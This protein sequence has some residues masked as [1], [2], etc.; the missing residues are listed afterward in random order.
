M[1]RALAD[2]GSPHIAA[3]SAGT[4][5]RST[6]ETT[7]LGLLQA[8]PQGRQRRL[9]D[10][11]RQR[12]RPVRR[13]RP[14]RRRG[15]RRLRRRGRAAGR[16]HRRG[17]RADLAASLPPAG[18]S[19]GVPRHRPRSWRSGWRRRWPSSPSSR[20]YADGAARG[21][22]TRWRPGPHRSR[23]SGCTAT[24]TWARCCARSDGW[25]VLDFEGE[26]ARPLAER[27][28]L[29]SPLRDVAGMLRSLR[30]RRP[31]PARRAP[32][33]P[34]LA[35]R[36]PEWAERNRQAFCDGYARAA[37]ADPRDESALLRAFELD[38]AVYEVRLR[39]AQPPVLA[40]DPARLHRPARRRCRV[41]GSDKRTP[42]RKPT[43]R[44]TPKAAPQPVSPKAAA[45]ATAPV[46]AP[47]EPATEAPADEAPA[48]R[49]SGRRG[50]R[51]GCRCSGRAGR[52]GERPGRTRGHRAGRRGRPV[53]PV[54]RG[55]GA[56]G[57]RRAPRPARRA[58]AHP[59]A[60]GVVLRT[61]R[62]EAERVVAHLAGNDVELAH[63]HAGVWEATVPGGSPDDYRLDGDLPR[64]ELPGGRP[65]PVPA[66]PRRG[67]PAPDRRGPARAALGRCSARTSAAT[68][69]R[70]GRSPAPRSPCGRPTPAACGSSATS[71]GWDGRGHPMRSL[72]SSGV[73]ELFVPGVG[74][75]THYK[76]ARPRRRRRSGARRPTRWP[77]RTEVPAADR[78][79][80]RRLDLRVGRRA[81]GWPSAARTP[82]HE[83]PMSIYEVHLG[84]LAAGAVL[85]SSWPTSSSS[86][87]V[88]AR[89]HPRGASAG[90]RAPVR[91]LL[92]L[93]GH[94][95]TTRRPS[96]FGV[97]R[98]LPLPGRPAAPGRHRRDRRLG[99]RALPEG[100]VG[101]GA[102]ST[103][104]RSTSTP[105]RGAASSWTGAPTSSTSAATRC[106]TSS[107]PTRSYWCE[108]FHV[109]G[110]R[111]DAVASMLYLDYSRKEGEWLPNQLRR[112]REPRR[113]GVPAGDERD[114]LPRGPGLHD[115]RRGVDRLAG[116]HPADPPRRPRLRLQVEHG[117]DARLARLHRPASRCTGA[118][119]TTR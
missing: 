101:A 62:P 15:R 20:R 117:L 47:A 69:P 38:K 81:P 111:V 78:E 5:G 71:T 98:R 72:G 40:A 65:L 88:C 19:R 1:T 77:S 86:T 115:H 41:T 7:T 50:T 82:V 99:A 94:R 52:A 54:P 103:A 102:A 109:D 22:T 61:L 32:G 68:T 4:T 10:G 87:S 12:P 91:R 113:G 55:A 112:P 18:G 118:T 70:T 85:P 63:V 25:V 73:W 75:G 44:S 21:P 9:G 11:H 66:H 76:F 45:E 59:V 39:G 90:R 105:T 60:D 28:A 17:A 64:P 37:G 79:R 96:R 116:R 6:G 95:A 35:Y 100:R 56:P 23:C 26:P 14:A 53:R 51:S 83:R 114:G 42:R 48:D 36:A 67:R 97:A 2:A 49:G 27:T 84:L 89:L 110:L 34:Q 93:P 108:E 107:S 43:P 106:A 13:G 57:R 46:V 8:V 104:P 30:L 29:M 3:R 74:A 31:A 16:G 119:T 80:G 33:D 58:G 92:G 24:C